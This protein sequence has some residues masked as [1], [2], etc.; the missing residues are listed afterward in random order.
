MNDLNLKRQKMVDVMVS[1]AL[2]MVENRDEFR[3]EKV[4]VVGDKSWHK[5]MVGLVASKLVETY[6]KPAL[7]FSIEDDVALGSGRSIPEFDMVQNLNKVSHHFTRF[8]GH[9]MAAGFE[10]PTGR[11]SQL[12]KDLSLVAKEVFG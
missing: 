8:G 6:N 4:I 10:L 12:R 7:A 11:L 5:G 3:D 9:A 2:E 1:D